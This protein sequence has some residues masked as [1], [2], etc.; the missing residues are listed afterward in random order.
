[1][2]AAVDIPAKVRQSPVKVAA[3]AGPS[4]SCCCAGRSGCGP[5]SGK[6]CSARQAPMPKRMLPDEIEKTLAKMGDDGEQG[7]RNARAR[8]RRVREEG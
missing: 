7:A 8:F 3:A 5:P 4:G 2:R 6:R 1:M